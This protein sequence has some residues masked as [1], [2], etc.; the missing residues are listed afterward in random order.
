MSEGENSQVG[1]QAGWAGLGVLGDEPTHMYVQQGVPFEHLG[2]PWGW[3]PSRAA[4]TGASGALGP[5][6]RLLCEMVGVRFMCSAAHKS[7]SVAVETVPGLGGAQAGGRI[8][9]GVSVPARQLSVSKIT[10]RKEF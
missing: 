1:A 5:E 2:V 8:H 3:P 10:S 4:D 9:A 6:T 7:V